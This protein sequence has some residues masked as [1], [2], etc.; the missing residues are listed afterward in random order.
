[1]EI[2]GRNSKFSHGNN[3]SNNV[4]AI[5]QNTS[6]RNYSTTWEKGKTRIT[7]G[8]ARRLTCC[9]DPAAAT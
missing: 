6:A 9:Q 1:M 8:E 3:S 2:Q 4:K 7:I 5:K